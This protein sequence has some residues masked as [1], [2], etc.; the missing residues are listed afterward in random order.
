MSFLFQITGNVAAVRTVKTLA[1]DP[2]PVDLV[3]REFCTS[4]VWFVSRNLQRN[5][6][7]AY[8]K[9]QLLGR[10]G[11]DP[12]L[13][14]L[15]RNA[16]LFNVFVNYRPTQLSKTKPNILGE[17]IVSR[18]NDYKMYSLHFVVLF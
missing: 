11:S 14:G 7:L 10:V 1:Q 6:F 4:F 16:A 12:K 15:H 3:H 2:S 17:T 18:G 13:V 8:C 9:V 5:L